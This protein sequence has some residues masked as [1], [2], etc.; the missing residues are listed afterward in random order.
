MRLP[1]QPVDICIHFT[2]VNLYLCLTGQQ[3]D[4]SPSS[5]SRQCGRYTL[6]HIYGTLSTCHH[7]YK[8]NTLLVVIYAQYPSSNILLISPPV[9]LSPSLQ[10][11]HF[12]IGNHCPIT[13]QYVKLSP[14]L[15]IIQCVTYTLRH[16]ICQA[17]TIFIEWTL[18]WWSSMPNILY[19]LPVNLSSSLQSGHFIVGHLCP[20]TY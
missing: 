16:I 5:H 15:H 6:K 14:P 19:I 18:C 10:S 4:L 3:V 9:D 11:G 1:G 20:V 13:H 17:V 12:I 8:R 7:I 2:L